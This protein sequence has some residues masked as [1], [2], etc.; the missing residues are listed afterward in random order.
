[1]SAD[2]PQLP[3]GT[4]AGLLESLSGF[5]RELRTAGIPVSL[6]ENL[7]AME[8]LQHVPIEDRET[9]KYALAATMV[10]NNAHWKTFETVFE[11]YFS[12]R[13]REY[14]ISEGGD[15]EAEELIADLLGRRDG[16]SSGSA[17]GLTHEQLAEMLYRALMD[18]N[19]A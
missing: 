19:E 8:A 6:T 11:V 14:H 15:A 4:S 12:L 18:G 1:M 16:E 2:P 13:G 7:D 9:F 5:V 3:L 17:D 10:K